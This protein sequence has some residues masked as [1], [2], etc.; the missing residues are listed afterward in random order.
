MG[1]AKLKRREPVG[2]YFGVETTDEGVERIYNTVKRYAVTPLRGESLLV[3]V[4]ISYYSCWLFFR[5][6]STVP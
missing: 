4:L 1:A 2:E 5:F 3:Q 6:C